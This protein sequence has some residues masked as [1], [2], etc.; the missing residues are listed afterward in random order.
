MIY[1][2]ADHNGFEAKAKILA[3]L[4]SGGHE[5]KDLGPLTFDKDDDYPDYAFK[6]GETV[7]RENARG[8]IVCGSGIGV[9]IAANKV[10]GVRAGYVES[11]EHAVK[12]M[13]DDNTNIL[14]LDNM[15]F[16]PATD[17]PIIETWLNTSFSE[18]ERHVRRLQK[19]ADYENR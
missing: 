4:E 3:F 11:T 9:C 6:L 8:I 5:A 16:D 17:F 12:A 2:A 14:V 13:E 1:I 18:F 15:T 7:V 10:K 19:I